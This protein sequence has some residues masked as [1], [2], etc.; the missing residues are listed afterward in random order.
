VL[1]A[2]L[3]NLVSDVVGGLRLSVL[4]EE[5]PHSRNESRLQS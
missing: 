3:F 4:E 2:T 1:L 5:L